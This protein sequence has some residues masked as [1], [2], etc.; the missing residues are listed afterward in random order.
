MSDNLQINATARS[1][2]GKAAMRRL[3]LANLVPG[4]IYGGGKDP[5]LFQMPHNELDHSLRNEAF[6]ASVLTVDVDGATEQAVLKDVQ[7]HPYK[8]QVLHLDLLRVSGSTKLTMTVPLHFINE[9]TAPGVKMAGGQ[10]SHAMTEVEIACLPADLPEFI[11]V[12]L[13]HLED[14]QAL[15]LSDLQLPDGVEI[16]SLAHGPDHD[17][18]VASIHKRGGG[19]AEGEGEEEGG[20]G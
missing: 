19:E 16:P 20:E 17:L 11:T 10:V 1:E 14:G 2:L 12:D 9:N 3:R 13:G 15:H 8:K 4:V 7:R 18:S 6:A 5:V